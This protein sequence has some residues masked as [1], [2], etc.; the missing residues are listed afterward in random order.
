MRLESA[1]RT[2]TEGLVSHGQAISGL[3][4]NIANANTPAF[5]GQRTEFVALLGEKADDR[6]ATVPAGAGDGVAVGRVRVDFGIGTSN[7]TGRGLDVALTGNGFFLVGDPKAPSLTRLGS[8]QVN[9]AGILTTSDGLPVL[10][11]SGTDA[12]VLGTINMVNLD[13]DPQPTTQIAL[14]GNVDGSA[15]TG[16]P[17][18]NPATFR[19][20]GATAAFVSTQS[21]FD[22]TGVRRDVQLF[23]YKTSPNQ[24]TVQAY[25]NGEDIGQAADLPVLLGQTTLNFNNVG[26]I[27]EEQQPQA[28]MNLNPAWAGGVAQTPF[29]IS[30]ANLTQYAGTSRIVNTQMDGRGTGDIVGF[31]IE[32]DGK[33]W[34]TTASGERIQAGTLALGDVTNRDGLM[35]ST[36]ALFSVTQESGALRV[37]RPLTD[38]LGGM[39]A[40][41]LEASNV[42]LPRQ[43]VD[44]IVFQRGYQAN[45]QVLSAASEL[46]KGTI[47]MIR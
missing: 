1:M 19:E 10:G 22:A 21:A 7:P 24:W 35:R 14:F 34:G 4:D 46:L 43:F 28:I 45:S 5:K 25:V 33:I 23:Y 18:A 30:L 26:Q 6:G 39:Q 41:A 27:P 29:T 42:D 17:P 16:Q 47:A 13:R 38:G 11:Y 3:G 44:M 20:V 36:G 32:G 37:G 40:G 15:P 8:F 31:E 12:E 2:S 9:N